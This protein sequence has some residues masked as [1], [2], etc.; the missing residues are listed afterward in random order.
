MNIIKSLSTIVI[1]LFT[2]ACQGQN[3]PTTPVVKQGENKIE[4][5]DFHSTHRCFT[6]NAIEA[7]T[8]HTL[9]TYFADQLKNGTIVFKVLN[10]DVEEN[11][12]EAE[13]FEAVG[14]ALFL[15]RIK[16]GKETKMDLTEFA[17]KQGRDKER[18]TQELKLKLEM[19]LKKL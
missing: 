13:K 15:N 6:C 16:N 5:I 10:V 14:T 8:L 19:E 9:N 1:A 11:E 12:A 3:T 2:Y 4:V 17:F 7:N 18:F